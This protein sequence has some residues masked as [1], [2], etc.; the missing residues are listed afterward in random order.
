M[1]VKTPVVK[2]TKQEPAPEPQAP[3]IGRPIPEFGAGRED[4]QPEKTPLEMYGFDNQIPLENEDGGIEE[5]PGSTDVHVPDEDDFAEGEKE[6][7]EAK[8]E[9]DA[10][11][12][13]RAAEMGIEEDDAKAFGS[14]E[15]LAL[16]VGAAINM[17]E[18]FLSKS[19]SQEPKKDE[20]SDDSGAVETDDESEFFFGKPP[21]KEE[22]DTFDGGF[23]DSQGD[24]GLKTGVQKLH[25]WHKQRHTKAQER[26]KQ[27]ESQVESLSKS[28]RQ[29]EAERYSE[30]FDSQ[31]AGLGDGY[32]ELLGQGPSADLEPGTEAYANRMKLVK[33]ITTLRKGYGDAAPGRSA[34][35]RQAL[36]AA[37]AE[38]A[39]RIARKGVESQVRDR[40][41]RFL[42]RP[43]PSKGE[44]S[45]A[46][47]ADDALAAAKRKFEAGL[48]RLQS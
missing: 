42:S 11:L 20:K 15:K 8:V 29:A 4:V 36:G 28:I 23:D 9:W 24:D 21:K 35:F 39:Q 16:A 46:G 10:D 2:T 43:T 47:S 33:A 3:D 34:L 13:K 45:R 26:I 22:P 14:P 19:Q 6:E 48:K 1:T 12:L 37:F 17:A 30:W 38:Q 5:E 40:Q 31:I 32:G 18:N 44:S 7:K 27:L 25:N 41:G